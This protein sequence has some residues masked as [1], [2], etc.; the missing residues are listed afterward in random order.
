MEIA[1]EGSTTVEPAAAWGTRGA[2]SRSEPPAGGDAEDSEPPGAFSALIPCAPLSAADS[3]V[4]CSATPSLGDGGGALEAGGGGSAD[5]GA[6]AEAGGGG[7]SEGGCA[8]EAGGGGSSDGGGASEALGGGSS[9]GG[10]A[11]ETGGGGS[12]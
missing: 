6:A 1:A 3:P 2:T 9:E 5:G 7:S 8:S 4:G 11:S 10:G 12:E